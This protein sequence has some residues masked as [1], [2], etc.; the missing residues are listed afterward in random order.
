MTRPPTRRRTAGALA[1][2]VLTGLSTGCGTGP[3]VP[4][5]RVL[6]IGDSITHGKAG[7]WTWRYRLWRS[8][9]EGGAGSVDF[10][11]PVEDLHSESRAYQ[12]PFFDRDHASLWGATLTP[13]AYAPA[14]LGREYRPDVV[15]IE[16]GVNDL[17]RDE[18]PAEVEAAMRDVVVQLREASPGVDVVVVRVPV[19]TVP[20]VPELNERFEGLAADL[21]T[22]DERVVVARAD[23][24][25]VPDPTVP[26]ADSYDG[27]H[28]SP[29][30]EVKIAASVA[31]A[32]A[33][34]GIGPSV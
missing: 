27:L 3:D 11:G 4:P 1:L 2:I 33:E 20:G 22:A 13:P 7:D 30:G 34:L 12:D 31:H 6:L 16:L 17:R 24:G 10:V 25:F 21:D 14:E 8:L 15:V 5:T 19:V 9:Q 26:G 32:L 28:P 23:D 18:P 29:S